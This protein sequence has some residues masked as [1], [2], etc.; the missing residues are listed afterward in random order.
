MTD[1]RPGLYR[2]KGRLVLIT[3]VLETYMTIPA[4][5]ERSVHMRLVDGIT[6][7]YVGRL[8]FVDGELERV[9]L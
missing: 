7:G 8:I 2:Y 4:L 9:E 1:L 5:N 3:D 6:D